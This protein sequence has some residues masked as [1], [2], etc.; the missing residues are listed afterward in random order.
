MAITLG[1]LPRLTA[2]AM[3]AISAANDLQPV[4]GG[5]TQRLARKGSRFALDVKVPAMS[6][7]GCGIGL[8]AD[9]LRGETETI[10]LPVPD[11]VPAVSYGTPLVN[12]GG[13]VGS[14]LPVDGLPNGCVI[15]KGKFLSVILGGQRYVHI[16]TAQTTANGSGQASLPIWPMLRTPTVDN[17]VV[18][19]AAPKIE[20]F[21]RPGQEWSI[22]RLRAVGVE[23]TVAE[24][25]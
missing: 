8:I 16:V 9:L 25:A 14:T 6:A 23:F 7:A 19:L 20:G 18:E 21:V 4:F 12:G 17:A 15:A 5:P 1:T 3:R 10:V 22:S 11:Y 2:Y 13:V 24:R